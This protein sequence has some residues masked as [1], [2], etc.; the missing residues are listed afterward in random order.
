VASAQAPS[1]PPA[2]PAPAKADYALP[3]VVTQKW[4]GNLDGMIKRRLI[5]VLV[6][7][8]KTLYFMDRGT[9]RG[10][11]HDTFRLFEEDLNNKL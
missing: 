1:K 4:T 5:R 11:I 2:E 10:L 3:H 7:Y 8:S 9:Q 6:P